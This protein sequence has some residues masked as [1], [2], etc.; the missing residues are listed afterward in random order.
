MSKSLGVNEDPKVIESLHMALLTKILCC[1][2][3]R[4]NAFFRLHDSQV[5]E[6]IREVFSK[7]KLSFQ[8]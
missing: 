6:L 5:F 7:S 4:K 8:M 1:F 3:S 2:D